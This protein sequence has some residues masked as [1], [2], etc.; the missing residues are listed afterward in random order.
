MTTQL[1]VHARLPILVL[2]LALFVAASRSNAIAQADAAFSVQ[3]QATVQVSPPQ[4]TLA[5]DPDPNTA[6]GYTIYRKS[7]TATSWGNPIATL[8][9]SALSYTD[10][11]VSV[12]STY[13]YQVVKQANADYNTISYSAY[14][15]VY[16]GINAPL[17][18]SRG[19]IVLLVATNS[20]GSLGAELARLQSDLAGD[21]W[22]VIRHDVSSNDTPARARSLVIADYNADPSNVQAVFLFGH[23]PILQS[24]FINYDGHGPRP[25]PAD[26]Y[27]G[28]MNGDWSSS[29]NTF[30]SD[31]ELMVGRVDFANMP[32]NGAP[33]PWPNETELLRNYLN[34]DHRWRF[35]QITAERRGLVADRFETLM[36]DMETRASTG[37]RT[38]APFVG[39]GNR[40]QA[41][42]SDTADPGNRW[43]SILSSGGA[44]LWTY[45]NGGGQDTSISELGLHGQYNDVWS[46]DI[47]AQDPKAVFF[48]LEGSHFGN[49]DTTDNIMRSVLATPTMGLTVCCISGHPQ[50]YIHHM[51]L[52]EPIGYGIRVTMNNSTLYRDTTNEFAQSVYIALMGDPSLRMEPVAPA[53]ALSASARTGAVSLAW[54]G[55]SDSV[56]G[57][58]VYRASSPNGPFTRLTTSPIT[59][60]S[61]QD[62]TAPSGTSTYMVRAIA[63]QQN[64]SGSYYNPSQGVFVNI[65]TTGAPNTPPT[66]SAI[67]DQTIDEN[68]STAAIGFTVNDVESAP[69]DLVVQASSSDQNL[70]PDNRISISGSGRNRSITVTPAVGQSGAATITVSVS[71]GTAATNT[72]FQLTVNDTSGGGGG[73]G[74]TAVVGT[75]NGLFFES[76]EVRQES[77]GAFEVSINSHG[78]YSGRLQMGNHRYAF[79]GKLDD[80][81]AAANTIS[82]GHDTPL[83]LSFQADANGQPDL[84]T[85]Q[86][87]DGAWTAALTAV[88]SGSGT[89]K[90]KNRWSGTYTV[91]FLGTNTDVSI[92]AGNGYATLRIN[93]TGQSTMAGTLADGTSFSQSAAVGDDGSLP[94]YAPL[95]NG[96][97]SLVSWLT[98]TNRPDD[99]LNGIVNWIKPAN[100]PR[101]RLYPGGFTNQIL[102]IGSIYHRPPG[103]N[104]AIDLSNDSVVFSGGNLAADFTNTITTA[105]SGRI[106]NQSSN[107]MTIN[108]SAATGKLTGSVV[109][110]SGGKA[111]PFS[112]MAFQRMNSGF[113]FMPGTDQSSSVTV[114][115]NVRPPF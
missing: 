104:H 48:L 53:S 3:V 56:I 13:E 44:W 112:G 59:T 70:V 96:Q 9:G 33:T 55:S 77:S 52:G 6:T 76:D 60:A 34:K 45:G 63:L 81:L 38:L 83:S 47:V 89:G 29:P 108:F 15:Y 72:S 88:R 115:P 64:F 49:W 2:S 66:I 105:K 39:L 35:K 106:S 17:T 16:S 36:P 7:K 14:G 71:D 99:D 94:L 18:D 24:G 21:G 37:Y 27:Y 58:H 19:K 97:G 114:S 23:V 51:G 65:N 73:V 110:P 26:G 40:F 12:G 87:S 75:Y 109:P 92:P 46:T 42:V 62:S 31:I 95:Y 102:A 79:N 68:T 57:Y 5:W 91:I 67:A 28:D 1:N 61:Y 113:G 22:Q 103:T 80:Q 8:P 111:I 50:Y 41:D 90:N 43:I 11:S 25:M 69:A 98:F 107:R 30:P 101:S 4:I 82:R 100:A 85:G 10:A 74:L 20:T 84:I 86:V 54:L 32:G 78:N 93:P